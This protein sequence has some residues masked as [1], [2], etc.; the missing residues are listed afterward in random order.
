MKYTDKL[1][2]PIWNK[3]ETDVFDIEQFNEGMQAVDDIVINILKQIDNLVIGDTN[4]DLNEYIKEEVFKELKKKVANKADKEEVEEISSQLDTKTSKEETKNI[5]VKLN[6]DIETINSQ[7]DTKANK[8][9]VNEEIAKAQLEGA[10][11]DTTNFAMKSDISDCIKIDGLFGKEGGDTEVNL[12]DSLTF[13]TG[14]IS[15]STGV[16]TDTPPSG[17]TVYACS[18]FFSSEND[19]TIFVPTGVKYR[20]FWYDKE[21]KKYVSGVAESTAT[22]TLSNQ[23]V[24]KVAVRLSDSTT[25]ES[26]N[27]VCDNIKNYITLTAIKTVE[28]TYGVITKEKL[29]NIGMSTK[30]D[31]ANISSQLG[32]NVLGA[33]CQLQDK[34]GDYYKIN[35][36]S[37]SGNVKGILQNNQTKWHDTT[38]KIYVDG[39]TQSETNTV[40]NR[41]SITINVD[42]MKIKQSLG[43]WCFIPSKYIVEN[44]ARDG[45]NRSCTPKITYKFYNNDNLITSF[46]QKPTRFANWCCGWYLHKFSIKDNGQNCYDNFAGHTINKIIIEISTL[47]KIPSFEMYIDCFVADQR[48]KPIFSYNLDDMFEEDETLE[49]AHYLYVNNI[50][51][52]C[53]I[54]FETDISTIEYMDIRSMTVE[55]LRSAK[56]TAQMIILKGYYE[57]LFDYGVYSNGAFQKKYN[58]AVDFLKT[59]VNNPYSI[60]N[61]TKSGDSNNN[62]I[63]RPIITSSNWQHKLDDTLRLA[64][65]KAGFKCIRGYG[66]ETY[67]VDNNSNVVNTLPYAQNYSSLNEITD[68][69]IEQQ[70]Q[71]IKTDIDTAI[72]RGS[73]INIFSHKVFPKD[74]LILQSTKIMPF[75]VIKKVLDYVLQLNANGDI[76]IMNM[77]NIYYNATR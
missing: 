62:S 8:Q 50:P 19:I 73:I 6:N 69:W 37:T 32:N 70:F 60:D 21:S 33:T 65:M 36:I 9:Y 20:Y 49:L 16:F 55:E 23:Y 31:I 27:S 11:V 12:V 51:V 43:M 24:Y 56:I 39:V 18:D 59:D 47:D 68:D 1:G 35:S 34:I 5:Q 66:K 3:P 25:V 54:N 17:Y 41:G 61:I 67:Y 4:I 63:V 14:N 45:V 72:I 77:D 42:D 7:L 57:G 48:L 38:L 13:T 29:R 15:S 58:V 30:E 74:R 76:Q 64:E 75:E 22:K 52:N 2:L 10:G 26:A 53:R 71:L 46:S 40:N 28:P 44:V